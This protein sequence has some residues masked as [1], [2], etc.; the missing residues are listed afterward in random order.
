[1]SG[2]ILMLISELMLISLKL[3]TIFSSTDHT[4][5][6]V[7]SD[8]NLNNNNNNNNNNNESAGPP[9]SIMSINNVSQVIEDLLDG[10]DIRLR[11]RFG[12]ILS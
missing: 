12:G 7:S 11:P 5:S 1:M 10:Y 2:S 6:T 9:A 4:N 3:G 8:H